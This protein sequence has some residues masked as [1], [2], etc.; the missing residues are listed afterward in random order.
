MSRTSDHS[1]TGAGPWSERRQPWIA[2]AASALFHLLVLLFALHAPSPVMT[3]PQGANSGSWVQV[4]FIGESDDPEPIPSVPPPSA[5]PA[6]APP[7]SRLRTTPVPL[8][9]AAPVPDRTT[10]PA[11]AA[12]PP[13]PPASVPQTSRRRPE[14]RGQPPGLIVQ[15][16]APDAPG[17]MHGP[18]T[19]RGHSRDPQPAES[20]L[21]LEGFHVYYDL[22]SEPRLRRWKEQGMTELFLPLPGS[23]NYMVCPLEVAL[24]R[25]S[26][27]CRALPSDS[28]ELADI[29]DAREVIQ[30]MQVYR[31][32]ELVWRGPGPYR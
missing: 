20:S 26:G 13:R 27:K 10:P 12:T 23:R 15:E 22:S 19:A 31:R 32:G 17:P 6:P 29:G 18:A 1:Q 7:A 16:L 3:P 25:D 21:E 28:P 24:R 14:A 5:A 4:D 8:A 11:P 30:V 2:A 9:D